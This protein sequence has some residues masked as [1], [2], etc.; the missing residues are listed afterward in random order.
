MKKRIILP[1]V[2]M[3]VLVVLCIPN[4]VNT[5]DNE[6][7][8]TSMKQENAIKAYNDLVGSFE[9]GEFGQ[10]IYPDEYCGAWIEEDHLVIALTDLE[11]IGEYT[12]L[13]GL[14]GSFVDFTQMEHSLND[15]LDLK[16]FISDD[17]VETYG[18]QTSFIAVEEDKNRLCVG[19]KKDQINSIQVS[20][21]DIYPLYFMDMDQVVPTT[22][23]LYG[24]MKL[25]NTTH[26]AGMT[27]STCGTWQ[28]NSVIVTCGH[29]TQAVGDTIKLNSSAGTTIGTVQYNRFYNGGYGDFEFVSVNSSLFDI[30]PYIL[31]SYT[32]S[33]YSVPVAP[34]TAVP[35]GTYVRFY[36]QATGYVSYGYV[37][38]TNS[39]ISVGGTSVTINGMSWIQVTNGSNTQGDSGGPVFSGTGT[40]VSYCGVLSGNTTSNGVFYVCFTPYQYMGY[41]GF[42]VKIS[43]EE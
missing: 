11:K 24:G 32:I 30:T 7:K 14:S 23:D 27:L 2:L 13:L 26:S 6:Y 41:I 10:Y 17:L 15:L 36:G 20:D 8:A 25:V 43:E 34:S 1:T 28:G 37:K 3:A 38:F 31:S 18:I 22:T 9:V 35:S 42:D 5:A 40:T 19:I 39:S 29:T 4:F 21:Y 33:G 12:S 16:Q